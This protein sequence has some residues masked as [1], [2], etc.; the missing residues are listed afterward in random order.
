MDAC[1][2]IIQDANIVVATGATG[3]T[4]LQAEHWQHTRTLNY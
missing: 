4:L 1:G 3:V 2:D